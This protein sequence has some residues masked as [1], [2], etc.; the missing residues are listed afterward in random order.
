LRIFA[1]YC[2]FFGACLFALPTH[3]NNKSKHI[4]DYNMSVELDPVTKKITGTQLI[5]WR[6]DSQDHVGD[7]WFHLYMNAFKNEKSTFMREWAKGRLGSFTPRMKDGHW[8]WTQVKKLQIVGGK[9]ITKDIRFVQPDDQNKDDQTVI[10][11]KL[12]SPVPPGGTI[13]LRTQFVTRLPR[14]FARSG[15][16]GDY[17][18]VGQWYPKLGVYEKAG[19]RGAKKGRWNCHQYHATSEYYADF[20]AYKVDITVPNSYI[21]GATGTQFT[22]KKHPKRPVT[23]HTFTQK[24]VHDFAWTAYKHYRKFVRIFKADR[25]VSLKERK[26]VAKRLGLPLSKVKLNDVK[27]I[28]LMQPYHV[29]LLERHVDALKQSLKLYGL[30]YGPYP[31]KVV[32]LVD[33]AWEGSERGFAGMEYATLFTAGTRWFVH[34]EQRGIEKLIVHEFG[35]QFFQGMLA[36][37][38]FEEPWLDE[39]INTYTDIKIMSKLYPRSQIIPRFLHLPMSFF[40]IK[41]DPLGMARVGHLALS[42]K[43]D[44]LSRAAWKFYSP[45]SYAKQSYAK[46]GLVLQTL[47]RVIGPQKMA[48]GMRLYADTWRYKHPYAKNFQDAINKAAGKDMTPFFKQFVHGTNVLDYGIGLLRSHKRKK[49]YRGV[50]DASK[51][52]KALV[53]KPKKRP[54]VRKPTKKKVIQTT[55]DLSKKKTKKKKE[56]VIYDS[57]VLVRRYGEAVWPVEIEFTFAD[58]KKLRKTWDGKYRWKRFSFSGPSRLI[59]A[60]VDPERKLLLDINYANNSRTL[61]PKARPQVSWSL[62]L[63][64]IVQNI[65]QF[66][67]SFLG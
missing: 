59:S 52:P 18:F 31:Y 43:L 39:G 1:F 40:S 44:R 58:G 28:F 56:K 10:R 20:G 9:D 54:A 65:L 55:I 49:K 11:V 6:N 42:P 22:S 29:H 32:T 2:V 47:E 48:R 26:A 16:R 23:T 41:N 7:L 27:M 63:L 12:P 25:D 21:V 38:E 61:K 37:N 36:T 51:P 46:T 33:P 45:V 15:Y 13:K 62:R 67:T 30:W 53:K 66:M 19:V 24:D 57:D 14:A 4:A 8:G 64:F 5:T 34:P 50:F 60:Q 35:H 17:F 3:A